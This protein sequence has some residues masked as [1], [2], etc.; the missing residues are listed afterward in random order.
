MDINKPTPTCPEEEAYLKYLD[1]HRKRIYK[2]FLRHGKLICLR[3]SLVG[4][5]SRELW[6]R[7]NRHDASKYGSDEFN[8]YRNIFYPRDGEEKDDAAFQKALQ[9][10]YATNDHHWQYWI[11]KNKPVEMK[12][13]AIAEMILD[14]EAMSAYRK[15]NPLD[16]YKEHASEFVMDRRTREN[17]EAVLNSLQKTMDY[18]Y[19]I[20]KSNRSKRS[21]KK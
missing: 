4:P 9:H 3:L 5:A 10:H 13:I 1:E 2:A 14:W 11:T 20:R 12:K 7:I 18:P 6:H 8:A 21:A 15:D 17:V 16:W 19:S